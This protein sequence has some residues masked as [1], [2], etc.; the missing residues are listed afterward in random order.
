MWLCRHASACSPGGV[1][2]EVLAFVNYSLIMDK[3]LRKVEHTK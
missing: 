1:G 2:G 3:V